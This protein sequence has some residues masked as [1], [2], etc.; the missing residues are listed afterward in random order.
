MSNWSAWKFTD[1]GKN[2]QLQAEAGHPL[3]FTKIMLGDGYPESTSDYKERTELLNPII[4]CPIASV[5]VEDNSFAK[6]SAVLSNSTLD[7]AVYIRELG[8][9]A[10]NPDTD[11][12]EL[13]AVAIDD[14]AD[15]I[16]AK[17]TAALITKTF[18][19][20]IMVSENE[21]VT[22]II[23]PAGIATIE[24]LSKAIK[25]LQAETQ[26]E[27]EAAKTTLSQTLNTT[28][29]VKLTNLGYQ[30]VTKLN[31]SAY[32]G[33]DIPIKQNADFVRPP[34]SVL[35]L[36]DDGITETDTACEFNDGDASDFVAN[37]GV[38]FTGGIMKPRTTFEIAMTEPTELA[39]GYIS[40]T[41]LI[42]MTNYKAVKAVDVR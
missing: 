12:E 7:E 10:K 21:E 31:T 11:E 30:Q 19:V 6:V 28:I 13:F 37:D 18:N 24:S 38:V 17:G 3:T 5:T 2:I 32:K 33:V 34:I 22:A 15:C 4:T 23:D 39:S 35:K 16:P 42:D 27:I 1:K 41:E 40:N 29:D 9:Y 8:L 20:H 14:A 26:K 25:E 36:R